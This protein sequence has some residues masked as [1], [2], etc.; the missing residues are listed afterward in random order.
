MA[1]V[2]V[3]VRHEDDLVVP[4]LVG[5][6]VLSD[7][8]AESE[9]Q[10][11]DLGEGEHLVEARLLDVQDLA[12]EREDRL[13]APVAPL[14]G[15]AAGRVA[16]HDEDLRKR[17][18]PFLAV[19][20]LSG[21]PRPVERALPP[22][23]LARLAGGLARPRRVH[24]LLDDA[25]RDLRVLLEE[26]RELLVRDRLR[27]GLRFLRNELL[28]R[29]RGELR[30][31]D[32]QRHDGREP[33]AAVVARE[34]RVLEVL[35]EAG[36]F[37]VLLDRAG[38]RRL[39]AFEVRAAVLV[40]DRVRE[41]ED[42]LGVALVPLERDVQALFLRVHGGVAARVLHV[43]ERDDRLVERLL[44]LVEVLDERADA[45][46]VPEQ[47]LFLALRVA[48][49]EDVDRDAGVQERELPQALREHVEV[50]A[51]D[52]EDLGVGLERD[53]RAGLGRLADLADRLERDAPGVVLLED[54]A[55]PLDLDLERSRKRVDDGKPH[56]MEAARDLVRVVVEL[57]ARVEVRQDDLQ[58]LA[59]VHGM[60]PDGDPAPV[61]F[62]GDRV[63]RV[64]DDGDRVAVPGLGLVDRVV[65][66]L[67]DHVVKA[68]DVV[69]VPDVHPGPLAHGLEPLEELDRA[70]AV[71]LGA[72]VRGLKRRKRL[73]QGRA[74]AAL[75]HR[76]PPA[77]ARFSG[78]RP[79]PRIPSR[80]SLPAVIR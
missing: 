30:V 40:R 22:H 51:R 29:L 55:F 35:R 34:R 3:G 46:V 78:L 2:H 16:L 79:A 43:G 36:A 75:A 48:L 80:A 23:E 1:A 21:E 19:R 44:V 15:R 42:L 53:L 5:I 32:L 49:V 54:L 72:R 13:R 66:E 47:V 33:F 67:G 77:A 25:A 28:L 65:H 64:D 17:G 37:G 11:A 12:L 14:L 45:A 9:D 50:V 57:A 8:R 38:E 31:A 59:P 27:P 60:G 4:D 76:G 71:V 68:R 39:Q 56:A 73:G 58:R 10:R 18:V 41:A 69:G 63:V 70:R 52:G 6:E 7:A 26:A 20:E 74:L 61:V 62:D 24:D